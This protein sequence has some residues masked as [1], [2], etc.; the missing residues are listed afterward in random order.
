MGEGRGFETRK[1]KLKKRKNE[2]KWLGG[3]KLRQYSIQYESVDLHK[4]YNGKR[5]TLG[6]REKVGEPKCY[7]TLESVGGRNRGEGR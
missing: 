3:G 5:I 1:S 4:K 2:R 6:A 7:A